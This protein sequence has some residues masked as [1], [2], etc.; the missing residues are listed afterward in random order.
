MNPDDASQIL[1]QTLQDQG[2]AA[3]WTITLPPFPGGDTSVGNWAFTAYVSD[4]S[5][6][7]DYSKEVTFAGK[8]SITGPAIYTAGE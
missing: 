6:D 1:L 4:L 8:L 7:I 2:T 3:D 5:F